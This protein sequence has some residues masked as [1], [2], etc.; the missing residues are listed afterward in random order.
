MSLQG[1]FLKSKERE[2]G[3]EKQKTL[4]SAP[5]SP[6]PAGN[7]GTSSLTNSNSEVQWP[8]VAGHRFWV[9]LSRPPVKVPLSTHI[10]VPFVPDS[11]SFTFSGHL[12]CVCRGVGMES[13]LPFTY[14]YG[15]GVI[16]LQKASPVLEAWSPECWYVNSS[17]GEI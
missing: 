5:A 13:Q 6:L 3:V 2:I 8:A 10:L 16:Y 17:R 12:W 9:V 11:S 15:M 14:Y 1:R 4:S 7:L